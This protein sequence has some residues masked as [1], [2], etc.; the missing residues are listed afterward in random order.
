MMRAS[1]IDRKGKGRA[2]PEP[3]AEA[4]GEVGAEAKMTAA[5]VLFGDGESELSE[6]DDEA[7]GRSEVAETTTATADGG[8]ATMTEERAGPVAGPSGGA[9]FSNEV[10]EGLSSEV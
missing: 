6:L 4:E 8:D 5:E 1:A 9:H 10:D 7:A 3:E 2:A